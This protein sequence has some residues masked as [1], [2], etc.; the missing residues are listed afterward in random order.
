LINHL[1]NEMQLTQSYKQVCSFEN[2][3]KI[4]KTFKMYSNNRLK[5][6]HEINIVQ[7]KL[8]F[9]TIEGTCILAIL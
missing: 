4:F 1:K 9:N 3:N 8:N 7:N 6:M 2:C 5:T